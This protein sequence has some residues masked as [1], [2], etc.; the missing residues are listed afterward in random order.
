MTG[1]VGSCLT[2][3]LGNKIQLVGD[4]IF[5]TNT[6]RLAEGIEKGICKFNSY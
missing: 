5:V 1:T 4:D 3:K 6:E 2:E